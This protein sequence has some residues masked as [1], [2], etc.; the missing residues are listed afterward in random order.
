VH[1][2]KTLL[3]GLLRERLGATLLTADRRLAAYAPVVRVGV[4]A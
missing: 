1:E 3:S 2:A 4:K